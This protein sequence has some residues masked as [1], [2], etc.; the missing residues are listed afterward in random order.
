MQS[1]AFTTG[2]LGIYE[3]SSGTYTPILVYHPSGLLG[4]GTSNPS[5]TFHVVGSDNSWQAYFGASGRIAGIWSGSGGGVNRAIFGT[6]DSGAQV[7]LNIGGNDYLTIATSGNVGIGT[8]SPGKKLTVY[9]GQTLQ[10]VGIATLNDLET[11][12]TRIGCRLY[13][14][15]LSGQTQSAALYIEVDPEEG[16]QPKDIFGILGGVTDNQEDGKGGFMKIT[17]EG[18]GDA[19]FIPMFTDGGSRR[20]SRFE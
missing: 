3:Y 5:A 7:R 9:E 4:V 2:N 11:I 13:P 12:A 17:H 8:T 20:R 1:G 6:P 18:A 10:E 16:G 19:I 14:V 15:G